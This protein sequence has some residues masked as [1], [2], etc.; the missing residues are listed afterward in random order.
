ML[1]CG[2]MVFGVPLSAGAQGGS[3]H[4]LLPASSQAPSAPLPENTTPSEKTDTAGVN[5]QDRRPS[6]VVSPAPVVSASDSVGRNLS[7]G[8]TPPVRR[9][10]PRRDSVSRME[11]QDTVRRDSLV[12]SRQQ[13]RQTKNFLEDRISGK[14]KDSLVYDLRQNMVYIYNQGDILYQDM[15]LK[16]DFMSVSLEDK[17]VHAYGIMDTV[18]M[19]PTRPEFIDGGQPYTMDTITYNFDTGKA[20]IKGVA[21]KEGDGYLIGRDIKKMPD[22][23]M[24][25]GVGRY[26]TCDHIDHPHWYFH[27]TKA[28]V[29]PKKKIIVGPTY[30]VMEDVPIPFFGIPF[31]FFPISS[32]RSSGFLIPSYGEET[33]RGFFLRDGGYYFA[34]NDYVDVTVTGGIYTLGSWETN[35]QSRYIKR[36][37]YSGSILATY[38]KVI[39]GD[40]GSSDYLNS[41]TYRLQWTHRQDPKFRPNSTFSASV[42]FMSSGYN[43]HGSNTLN[44]YLNTQTNSSIAYSKTWAG[45]PFSFSTNMQHSQNSKDS[46]ISISFPNVVFSV[47]RIYPFKRKAA[48]GKE[49]WYERISISYSGSLSNRISNVKQDELFKGNILDKM[50]NGIKHSIPISTTFNFFNYLNFNPSMQYNEHWAF[51]KIEREWSPEENRVKEDT[52]YGFFRQYDFSISGSFNTKIY[53]EFQFTGKN[54]AVKAIRHV[55]TPSVGFSYAPNFRDPKFGFWKAYQS[56]STGT[57]SYY[58]PTQNALNAISPRTASASINYSLSQTLE[59]KVRSKADT[60]GTRKIKIIDNISLSGSYNFLAESFKFSTIGWSIR[61]TIFKGFGLNVSGSLDPY[62][63]DSKG[64]RVDRLMWK[65]GKIGRI[66]NASTSFGY[67]FNSGQKN[68]PVVNDINSG[69]AEEHMLATNSFFDNNGN[70]LDPATRRAL[71]TSR[72]YDFS[73]PWNISFN[74]SLSYYNRG[75]KKEIIQSLG[76]NGSV[77]LTEKWGVTFTGGYDFEAKKLTPSSF[78]INRDLH[79][80]QMSFSWIPTGYMKSWS[81]NIHIKSNILRDVK[82]DRSSSRYDNVVY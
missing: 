29:V 70:E 11:P 79:C 43:K 68:M 14:N 30:F 28:K 19:V 22:N 58:S 52:T 63:V 64:N 66:T 18:Y 6:P 54:P 45:K 9:F 59:A 67:S 34:F 40:K 7:L 38:T 35:V 56:D 81:F 23:T 24:N 20:K 78:S 33:R 17:T 37:K 65:D 3:E 15:N 60:T 51:R 16:A 82:Y 46:T 76:F 57:I 44:D 25:V 31:G 4:D 53:G 71:L 12:G 5:V 50:N 32:G 49:K 13:K 72:Y 8:D 41:D 39:E 55:I 10:L 80:W 42:N 36:Y 47:S 74:Y 26:T 73:I 69:T 62:D 2:Y 1:L 61:S 48:T 21:T 75:L 77:T 27:M